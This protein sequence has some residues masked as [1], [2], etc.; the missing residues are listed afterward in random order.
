MGLHRM[1]VNVTFR[2]PVY[3]Y[4]C[5]KEEISVTPNPAQLNGVFVE[6]LRNFRLWLLGLSSAGAALLSLSVAVLS[7]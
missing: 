1:S 3:A 5:S 2:S 7:G 4:I 6:K